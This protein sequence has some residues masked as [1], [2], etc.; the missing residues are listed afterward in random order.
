MKNRRIII[1]FIIFGILFMSSSSCSDD[2]DKLEINE[3][4]LSEIIWHGM[5]TKMRESGN[6]EYHIS[7]SFNN[8]KYGYYYI[9]DEEYG[10][11]DKSHTVEY[12]IKEKSMYVIGGE[13]T[14]N[15]W[16]YKSTKNELELRRNVE[17]KTAT[18]ILELSREF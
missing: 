5:L 15:W 18:D 4:A 13:L 8:S 14:G 7:V 9:S 11:Y 1:S 6:E 3:Q 17:D 2:D 12:S 16:F 10:S